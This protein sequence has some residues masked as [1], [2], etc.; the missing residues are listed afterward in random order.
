ML[1]EA[2]IQ[3]GMKLQLVGKKA[4]PNKSVMM[5]MMM[6][7]TL[8]KMVFDG[9]KGSISSQG[10]VTPM[11]EES[12][13]DLIK[14]TQP[15]EEVGMI[16]DD[17]VKFVS[18]EEEDGKTLNVLEYKGAEGNVFLYF[19]SK[20]G[21]KYKQIVIAKMPDGSNLEQASYFKEYK[22]VN[23]VLFPFT[24]GIPVGPQNIEAKVV[25]YTINPPITD[26]DFTVEN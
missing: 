13:K 14:S 10:M 25:N 21:L 4:E 7:N 26:S 18:V 19:D 3:P 1:A 11:P 5:I 8:M 17:N 23:G 2:E 16:T 20:T 15:I 6:G 9:E 24:L 12:V 22:E